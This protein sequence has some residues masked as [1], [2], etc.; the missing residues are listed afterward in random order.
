M[1]LKM[2]GLGGVPGIG[3]SRSRLYCFAFVPPCSPPLLSS[4][5]C[6]RVDRSPHWLMSTVR[7]LAGMAGEEE[8]GEEE[9]EA[10]RGRL[11]KNGAC[12]GDEGGG[13]PRLPR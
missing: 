8:K 4:T 12:G 9:G 2:H 3:F 13:G 5:R 10:I 6:T 1:T 7:W 11:G